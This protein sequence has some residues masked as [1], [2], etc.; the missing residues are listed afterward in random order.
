[1][2]IFFFANNIIPKAEFNF[3]N[4]R[5]NIAKVK[6]AFAIAEGQFND[7]GNLNIK[8]DKKTGDRG[9]FLENVLIHQ[10]KSKM[11]G[12]YTVMISEN[13]E[14]K[15]EENSDILQLVLYN[16][17]YDDEV[18]PK[19]VKEREKKPHVKSYFDTY[20]INVDLGRLNEVDFE[21]SPAVN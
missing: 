10:K 3:Y 14:L 5:K 20:T 9:Q 1:M 21:E 7:L 18:V 13:G 11:A 2:L 8:V 19:D 15:S 6:P 12:N 16:G 17:N 4:L